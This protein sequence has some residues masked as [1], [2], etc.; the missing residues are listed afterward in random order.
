VVAAHL[1]AGWGLLQVDAVRQAVGEMAPLMVEMIAP[2][3]PPVVLRPP[4]PPAPVRPQPKAPA[5]SPVLSVAPSPAPATFE[6]PAPPPEPP[7][8]AP[9]VVV[10]AQPAPPA[11]PAPPAQ[12]KTITTAD[13]DYLVRP[14]P[15][16]PKQS[17]RF[18]ETGVAHVR[19]LVDA[20]GVPRQ[21]SVVRS[22]GFSR[23]DEEALRA[24]RGIRF[25]PYTENGVAQ[26]VWR[27]QPFNF[28][29]S[30]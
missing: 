25:K 6:T 28:E 1:A 12:P 29:P 21:L 23:L 5:P 18:G 4:P 9:V 30:R 17:E 15:V 11:P 19:M 13:V 22:T 8:P 3:A 26:P 24:S 20:D 10:E 16:Y 2:P 7:A 27:I 14:T